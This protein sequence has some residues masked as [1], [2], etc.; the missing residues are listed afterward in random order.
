MDISAILFK[1]PR[2]GKSV[3]IAPNATVIGNVSLGDECSVWFGAILRADLDKITIGSRTNIQDNAVIHVDEGVPVNIGHDVKI[4]H[5][6][7]IHGATIGN[8]VL[9][10]MHS[11]IMNNVNIGDFCII[12]AHS[13]LTQGTR[14][15]PNSLV[16]GSPAKVVRQL[17]EMELEDLKDNGEDYVALAGRYLKHFE[18]NQ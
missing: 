1:E 9:I 17:S 8:H 15:P 4:G 16:L 2:I 6:A 18:K 12:G 14:I 7:L 11:T 10:G 13:L 5:L 3:F